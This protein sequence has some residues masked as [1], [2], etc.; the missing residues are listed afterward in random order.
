MSRIIL[1]I[2]GEALKGT[3][4]VVDKKKL[5]IVL[6][7][8]T[9]LQKNHE[10]GIVIG[11]GNIF[12]GREHSDMDK[13]TG[14]TIGMLGTV[15][16]A[17]Y[18]KDYLE[19]NNI[20]CLVSTPFSFPNLIPNYEDTELKE[21]YDKKKIILFGGGIGKSGYSTDSGTVLAASKVD[22]NLIIKMTN[23][24]GVYN[25]DPKI[26]KNATKFDYLSYEDV[27]KNEYKVMDSYAFKECMKRKIKILVLNF[28]DYEKINDY[29]KGIRVGTI[30]GD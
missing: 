9:M 30:V 19:K 15:M 7:T 22:A 8:I 26:N 17:L 16:N 25:D 21:S 4:D 1:K 3:D 12:R 29:F 27:I 5:D 13:V 24:D 2:S 28:N 20:E 14:D 6:K 11:G 18:L 10:I 23:V